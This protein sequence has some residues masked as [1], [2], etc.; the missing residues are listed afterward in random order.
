MSIFITATV[1]IAT[2]VAFYYVKSVKSSGESVRITAINT[3]NTITTTTKG[4]GG[5]ILHI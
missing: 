2:I 4:L 3:V 1:V 5:K